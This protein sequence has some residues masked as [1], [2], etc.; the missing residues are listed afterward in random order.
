[1]ATTVL[2]GVAFNA[3]LKAA[4]LATAGVEA[5]AAAMVAAAE[6]AAATGIGS[7]VTG[8]VTLVCT[9]ESSGVFDYVWSDIRFKDGWIE[10]IKRKGNRVIVE[11]IMTTDLAYYIAK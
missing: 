5:T 11:K 10:K 4:S 1:M 7:G 6:L 3:A 2:G 9:F 8:F